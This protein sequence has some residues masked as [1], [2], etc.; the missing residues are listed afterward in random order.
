MQ[1]VADAV[2][3]V[4]RS[5]IELNHNFIKL[6]FGKWSQ[7]NAIAIT[8]VDV[9]PSI[10]E[11]TVINLTSDS[12]EE[13]IPLIQQR[14]EKRSETRRAHIAFIII[15]DE[16]IHFIEFITKNSSIRMKHNDSE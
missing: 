14:A 10:N 9:R 2:R 15:F 16:M 12:E 13:N 1:S 5:E 8:W 7:H 6:Q 3:L 11:L 4:I